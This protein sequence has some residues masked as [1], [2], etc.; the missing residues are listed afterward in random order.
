MN[1]HSPIAFHTASVIFETPSHAALLEKVGVRQL[2]SDVVDE[3]VGLAT[4]QGCKFPTDFKQKTI[5]EMAQPTP[6]DSIM[7]QDFL[8]RRPMEVETYLGSPIKSAQTV[9]VK[10][11]RI[12]TLYSILYNLNLVN[13]TRPKDTPSSLGSPSAQSP[14]PPRI[15]SQPPSR[16]VPNSVPNGNGMGARPRPR[17]PPMSGPMPPGPRRPPMN[18]GGRP[19]MNGHPNGYFSP[20]SRQ[21]SRRGSVEGADLEE[22]SHLVLY[23]DIPE[24]GQS[25]YGPPG[26]P[27]ELALRERELQLRQRELALR[28]REMTMGRRPMPM[29]MPGPGPRRGPPSQRGNGPSFDDDDDDDDDYFDSSYG[30]SVRMIDPDN[31][32]MMSVTSK[33]N[34]KVP[35]ASDFRKNPDMEA[36]YKRGGRFRPGFGRSRSSQVMASTMPSLRDNILND[37]MLGY[38]SNRYGNVDRGAMHAESRANSLTA[39]RLDEM[40]LGPSGGGP[41]MNGHPPRRTSQSP[42]NIYSPSTRGGRP[43]PPDAMRQTLP[44]HPSNQGNPVAPPQAEQHLG[45]SFHQSKNKSVPSLTGSA[46]ASAGSGDSTRLD[47]ENSAHSSQSSLGPRPPIGVR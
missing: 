6:H 13:R 45:V 42:A 7:Y 31:F 15:S 14:L 20:S 44:R 24:T 22:F 19:S 12:E 35:N 27:Q 26:G 41:L 8:A 39:S 1:A 3:L 11:P 34:R 32:D 37:P 36:A 30:P 25:E 43:S 10:V 46:S 2:V 9:G 47:S 23:D 21:A 40:Q 5:E 38:S 4:A 16:N 17:G 33:K 28:E 18:V 29:P